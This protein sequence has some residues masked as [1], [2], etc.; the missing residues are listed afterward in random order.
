MWRYLHYLDPT[1]EIRNETSAP[2]LGLYS[3][4]IPKKLGDGE[5]EFRLFSRYGFVDENYTELFNRIL[6]E[7]SIINVL[8][9]LMQSCK[10]AALMTQNNR[11]TPTKC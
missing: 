10:D 4:P 6:S 9:K 11:M 7:Q 8:K 3:S 1:R 5:L 2:L